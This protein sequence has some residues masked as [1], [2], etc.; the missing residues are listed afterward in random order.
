MLS[1]QARMYS[2]LFTTEEPSDATWEQEL[3]RTSE[4]VLPGA[5]V[6]PSLLKWSPV[7]EMHFQFER[8]GFFVVD[9]DSTAGGTYVFNLT[10]G[11]KDSKPKTANT[12]DPTAGKSRK[13]EQ[14]RQ[15]AEKMVR[16]LFRS[17]FFLLCAILF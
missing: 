10:V 5:L 7:P 11:L 15:L 2:P 4:V 9:K 13:E 8:L 6:D 17:L 3:N 12:N 16:L 14:A 1:M